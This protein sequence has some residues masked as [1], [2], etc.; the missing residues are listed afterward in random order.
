MEVIVSVPD[1]CIFIS[2][3]FIATLLSRVPTDLCGNVYAN[4]VVAVQNP[5]ASDSIRQKILRIQ[6][7]RK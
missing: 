3:A 7:V 2:F 1:H 6:I 4:V 5:V